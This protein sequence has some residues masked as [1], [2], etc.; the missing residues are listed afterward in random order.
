M[1]NEIKQIKKEY[2]KNNNQIN[3]F[4]ELD[5]MDLDIKNVINDKEEIYNGLKEKYEH[6]N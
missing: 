1:K 2:D 6:T 5:K 4:E 3:A